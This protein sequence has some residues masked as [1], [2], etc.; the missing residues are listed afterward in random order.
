MHKFQNRERSTMHHN[1]AE[2]IESSLNNWKGQCWQWDN[3]PQFGSL[4]SI[5]TTDRTFF[6]LVYEIQTHS[7]DPHRTP[8]AYQKSEVEL[9]KEQP[10]IFEFLHT[11]FSCLTVGYSQNSTLLYQLAPEPPKIH[12]FISLANREQVLQFFMQ[13][14]YLH[15]IFSFPHQSFA[16]DELL[17]ALLK[18]LSD[19]KVLTEPLLVTFLETFSLLTANDYRRLKIF[20]QRAGPLLQIPAQ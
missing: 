1:F 14:Q 12:S 6:G 19:L 4:V 5:E 3:F 17:L 20:L 13:E 10:Q 16:L 9:K 15:L 11:T 8:I 7:L 2:V 18:R